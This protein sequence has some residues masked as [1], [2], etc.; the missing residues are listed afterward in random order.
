VALST[1]DEVEGLALLEANTAAVRHRQAAH[2]QAPIELGVHR[3]V[4]VVATEDSV[5]YQVF[6]ECLT[7]LGKIPGDIKIVRGGQRGSVSWVQGRHS[8]RLHL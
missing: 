7:V 8:G 2:A 5:V 4:A 3:A 1:S 6:G